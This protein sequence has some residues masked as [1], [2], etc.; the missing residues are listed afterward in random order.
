GERLDFHIYVDAVRNWP[1]AS[2]YD[3]RD[4]LVGLGFTYPPFAAIAIWPLARLSS[5]LAEHLW[6]VATVA[7]SLVFFLMAEARLPARPRRRWYPAALVSIS[8]WTV[9][10]VLTVRLGQINGVLALAV[11]WDLIAARRG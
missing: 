4:P 9:P 3:Y 7:S 2:V 1:T 11:L 10:V 6:L 5:T 8:L